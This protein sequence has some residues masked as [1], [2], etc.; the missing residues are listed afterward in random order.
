MAP[1]TRNDSPRFEQAAD[2]QSPEDRVQ[3]DHL[4]TLSNALAVLIPAAVC[5]RLRSRGR[6]VR[7]SHSLNTASPSDVPVKEPPLVFVTAR[8]TRYPFLKN[9]VSQVS[10][11]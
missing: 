11:V 2:E 1:A 8:N 4:E 6:Q 10:E 9:P 7:E 5:G 3:S